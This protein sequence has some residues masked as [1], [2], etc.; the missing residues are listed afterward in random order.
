[1]LTEMI[2]WAFSSFAYVITLTLL[3]NLRISTILINLAFRCNL[4]ASTLNTLISWFALYQHTYIKY[5]LSHTFIIFTNV[6]RL[7][8][9]TYYTFGFRWYAFS[10]LTSR[11]C[12][13]HKST[14][15]CTFSRL[16][17]TELIGITLRVRFAFWWR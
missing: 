8:V 15:I 17:V 2:S 5:K 13:F 6:F 11:W 16:F 12:T 7:T 9:L 4:Y 10:F 3:A 14:F 1:M